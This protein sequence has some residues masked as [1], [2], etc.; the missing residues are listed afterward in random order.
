MIDLLI[1]VLGRPDNAQK[2]ADSIHA[3]TRVPHIIVFLCTR[4]D[5]AE[6][7]ACKATRSTVHLVD[8]GP[9]EYARKINAG[10]EANYGKCEFIFTGADDLHF[11]AGWDLIAIRAW[12]TT[13][14]PVIGTN[15]LGNPSVVAGR[16]STHTLVH[17]SYLEQ[18]TA[19]E[20]DK[21][22]H[23]GYYHNF[24]DT[25]FIETAKA[26][27]AFTFAADSRVEHLHP[28]WKKGADDVIYQVA[29]E[30]YREDER[31]FQRRSRLWRRGR[32]R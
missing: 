23:D 7:E 5:T 2:V 3:A 6:I 11:H 19:D 29:R 20:P 24:C 28:F 10:A 1:P 14:C 17:R 15:D 31:H 18:G 26:R 16:H 8:P 12:Q 32:G 22:L 4:G 27:G 21:V 30:H 9:G 25:E 13:G